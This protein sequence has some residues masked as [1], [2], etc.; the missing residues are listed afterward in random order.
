MSF[1]VMRLLGQSELVACFHLFDHQGRR[2][3]V[4]LVA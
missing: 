1:G 3:Q 4:N 2:N